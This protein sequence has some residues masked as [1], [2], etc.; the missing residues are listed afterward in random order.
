MYLIPRVSCAHA[1]RQAT[2]PEYILRNYLAQ[3]VI[4]QA[5]ISGFA[6]LEHVLNVLRAPYDE[7]PLAEHYAAA[8]DWASNIQVRCSS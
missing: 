3:A 4:E 7:Q 1:R 6:E 5:E 8:P 2:N